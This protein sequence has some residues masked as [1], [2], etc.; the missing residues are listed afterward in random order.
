MTF[1]SIKAP[2]TYVVHPDW[3]TFKTEHGLHL[4]EESFDHSDEM[5][6]HLY[7]VD[8]I[9]VAK[10]DSF[11]GNVGDRLYFTWNGVAFNRCISPIEQSN[12]FAL[13]KAW[14]AYKHN[15]ELFA[16][17]DFVL[18]KPIIKSSS[19]KTTESGLLLSGYSLLGSME[20]VEFEE[21]EENANLCGTIAVLPNDSI[22]LSVGDHVCIVTTSDVKVEIDGVKYFRTR[23]SE[24]LFKYGRESE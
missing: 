3:R 19:E 6:V 10:P 13:N 16:L 5:P 24:I 12:L 4:G 15:E 2:N 7:P 9:I 11:E 1:D 8:G 18:L 21:I 23:L 20:E 14:Y 17:E 22:G